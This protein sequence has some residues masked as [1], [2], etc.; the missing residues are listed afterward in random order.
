MLEV[1]T[2]STS[3]SSS[4]APKSIGS[5]VP[6]PTVEKSDMTMKPIAAEVDLLDLSDFTP[7]PTPQITVGSPLIDQSSAPQLSPVEP[8]A[9]LDASLPAPKK[10]LAANIHVSYF[11]V[12]QHASSV[13]TALIPE[14]PP[15][16]TNK[17]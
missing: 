6:T 14:I 3:D 1:I 12:A 11:T 13:T 17:A 7:T 9:A 4:P 16:I 2:F 5:P 8:S 15:T 10:K